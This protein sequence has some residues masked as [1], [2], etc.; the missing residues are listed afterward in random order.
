MRTRPAG[1]A[2]AAMPAFLEMEKDR[3]DAIIVQPSLPTK[4]VDR[5]TEIDMYRQSAT[6][7]DRILKGANPAELPIRQPTKFELI[8]N[9]KTAKAIG[10]IVPPAF[11]TRAN[12]VIE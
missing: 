6:Y 5:A 4:R 11:L 1:R 8:I 9:M 2:L 3:P 10:M 12:E 7:V